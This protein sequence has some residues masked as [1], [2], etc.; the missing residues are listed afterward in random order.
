M[1]FVAE[2]LDKIVILLVR[3]PLHIEIPDQVEDIDACVY[4]KVVKHKEGQSDVECAGEF[5]PQ[6]QHHNHGDEEKNGAQAKFLRKQKR[7]Y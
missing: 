5:L 7:Y 3:Y 1:R 6:V 4:G 2:G